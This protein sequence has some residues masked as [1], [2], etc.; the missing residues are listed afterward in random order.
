[1]P[2]YRR[3]YY[4]RGRSGYGYRGYNR[5]WRRRGWYRR[6]GVARSSTQGT[7][8]FSVVVPTQASFNFTVAG[9]SYWSDLH[10]IAPYDSRGGATRHCSLPS[11]LLYRT[12]TRLY[13]QVKIDWVSVRI[14]IMSLV[15]SG[16]VTPAV[17]V[18][19][20]WDR[21]LSNDDASNPDNVPTPDSIQNGS[22]SQI[23]LIVNNSRAIV[24][25]FNGANDLQERTLF[26]DGSLSSLSGGYVDAAFLEG[27][28]CGYVP[29]LYIALNTATSPGA[30]NSFSFTC[31]LDV[32]WRVT[33]RNPKYG[34][35][36]SSG[37]KAVGDLTSDL[38]TLRA[39]AVKSEGAGKSVA[40]K[41]TFDAGALSDVLPT[42]SGLLGDVV[43]R[44]SA[45]S[46]VEGVYD[47]GVYSHDEDVKFAYEKLGDE[48]FHELF[49]NVYDLSLKEQGLIVVDQKDGDVLIKEA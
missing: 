30:G 36:V 46:H 42:Y 4:R 34:L 21:A 23:S 2:F 20:M 26:H 41:V 49:K 7:R 48:K 15:G 39:E 16:G 6:G 47:D 18:V 9:G 40:K 8:R 33:F 10:A 37:S 22:E 31:S 3:G 28:N 35:S 17:K 25:R 1:M 13:D 11:S 44:L 32:K 38:E 24:N 14:S 29:A 45:N 27:Q 12:Y 19:T 43:D 5:S